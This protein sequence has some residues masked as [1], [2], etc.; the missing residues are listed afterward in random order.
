M[1]RKLQLE[2]LARL[3][4]VSDPRISPDGDEVA[5]VVS[6]IDLARNETQGAIWL[7][8]FAGGEPRQVT[9]GERHDS[10]PRWSPAASGARSGASGARSGVSGARNGSRSRWLAFVSDRSG[11]PEL[12]ALPLEGGEPR[13]LTPPVD[14]CP[15]QKVE[16]PAWS[17]D[18]ARLAY[19]APG[20][21]LRGEP[22]PT[23]EKDS[24]RRMLRV[25]THRH[26]RDGEGFH[27]PARK[28]LW[29]VGLDGTPPVQLTDGPWDDGQPAWSP[30]GREIAFVS[31][32]SDERD[33]HFEGG[34]LH[35][36]DVANGRVRRLTNETGRARAPAWSPDGAWIAYV[37]STV[38]D[39]ASP[40]DAQ[41]WRVP[42]AG[43]EPTCLS[44]RLGRSVGQRPGGYL[45]PSP[46]VW[47]GDGLLYLVNTGGSTDLWRIGLDGGL[48]GLTRGEHAA[49][50]F[51]ADR[52]GRRCALLV[53]DPTTPPEV[54]AWDEVGGLRPLTR[55][56][57]E[58]LGELELVR[59]ERL[60]LARPDGPTVEGWLLPPHPR[61]GSGEVGLVLSVHGGP[62]NFFGNSWNFDHQLYAA[63][64]WAV[65]YAN[66]RGSG[67]YG[68]EFA[69][70]VIADW[71]GGD[72]QDLLAFVD[73][74]I[75]RRDP[76]ID[77]AR[78]AIT[79]SSYGGFMTCWAVTQTDRFAVGVAGAS[80]TNLVSFFGT[81][82]IGASW[83]VHEMG[84]L[85]H[86]RRDV[87]L[88][89][90]PISHV[91]RVRTPL[92]LYH[93]EADLRC[94]IEQS[95]QMFSALHRLSQTVELLRIPG[96]AHGALA[97]GSP[98][99]RIEARRV[100]LEWL[101]RFL[102]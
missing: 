65:L 29:V 69:S 63:R 43:G 74:T 95:E 21:D 41:L 48:E 23:A 27:G 64:G 93:G 76:P 58:L 42:S 13:R 84:G 31:D 35:V 59:A 54:F 94:P 26:K 77:S 15:V 99:H 101:G 10:A 40:S 28:H 87:Y 72:L 25:T 66:P 4:A 36:V 9:A 55:T 81:S 60:E 90:S 37:G 83:G 96:E 2:D 46:P 100:I 78:L 7:V 19:V 56:N 6:R 89:R 32:R 44:A 16:E 70:R 68:E 53:G 88:E 62:H 79:G 12:Y 61:G 86:E 75:A 85:P 14:G 11:S 91:E 5:Y 102:R 98:V 52:V 20:A 24:R 18:G 1:T 39:E 51:G 97:A 30:D 45:T 3:A 34:A 80:I 50:D 22:V 82:D 47:S 73:H 38:A 71:G 67:G 8:P 57:A 33:R 17:P 49:S 92:L